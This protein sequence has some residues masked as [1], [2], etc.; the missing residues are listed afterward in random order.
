MSFSPVVRLINKSNKAS[1][2]NKEV[3]VSAKTNIEKVRFSAGIL[4][5][6]C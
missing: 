1:M 2:Q 6:S 4:S 3:R 5:L